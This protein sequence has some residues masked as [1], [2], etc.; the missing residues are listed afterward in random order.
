MRS[1]TYRKAKLGDRHFRQSRFTVL[2]RSYSVLFFLLIPVIA[3]VTPLAALPSISRSVGSSGWADIAVGQSLGA[4]AA[5]IGE[6]G[7][8]V[9]GPQLVAR[10]SSSE[11]RAL[12]QR[13]LASK[14]ISGTFL[15]LLAGVIAVILA[16]ELGVT[17][18]L[19]ALVSGLSCLNS[20]WFFI[21]QNRPLTIILTDSVPRLVGVLAAAL[22]MDLGADIVVFPLGLLLGVIVSFV[23]GSRAAGALALPA[24]SDFESVCATVK[25]QRVVVAGRAVS[26][27]YTALPIAIVG[28]LSPSS[29]AAFAAAER[30]MRMGLNAVSAIPNRLQH[31]LGSAPQRDLSR[32]IKVSL[33]INFGVGVISSSAFFLLAPTAIE[34]LFAGTVAVESGPLALAAGVV[35]LVCMSRG[36]GLALVAADRVGLISVST[37]ASAVVGVASFLWLVPAFGAAG[38]FGA[39]IAA[40]LCGLVIQGG[41]LHLWL[42]RR[43]AR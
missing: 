9:I 8:S 42:R 34:F 5:I 11:Q 3:A 39:E 36:Y 6:L 4:A 24:R 7:W 12:F 14:I 17:A 13:A 18:G 16:K 2:K 25:A 30:L 10:S 35:L 38:G 37:V 22:A 33:G 15:S 19:V 26:S 23:L 20:V 21:G 27:L 28:I 41:V 40:E 31:W 43:R 29:V 32:R 1:L